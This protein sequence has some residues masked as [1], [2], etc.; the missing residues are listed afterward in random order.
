M[1]SQKVKDVKSLYSILTTVATTNSPIHDMKAISMFPGHS[2]ELAPINLLYK[3]IMKG[4]K[5]K[6]KKTRKKRQGIL[7]FFQF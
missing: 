6:M 1:E 5:G 3:D 7:Q 4:K 2:G